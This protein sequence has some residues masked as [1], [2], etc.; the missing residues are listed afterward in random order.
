MADKQ[1]LLFPAFVLQVKEWHQKL[2]CKCMCG[3]S[4]AST[5]KSHWIPGSL[6][7]PQRLFIGSINDGA[8]VSDT[9][10]QLDKN[11]KALL[12]K[13]IEP[14]ACFYHLLL[15]IY[16]AIYL[17]GHFVQQANRYDMLPCAVL[18]C[19][20]KAVRWLLSKCSFLSSIGSDQ[21]RFR[22]LYFCIQLQLC[23]N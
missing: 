13:T 12:L 14:V 6:D 15:Y 11:Q 8:L 2:A 22:C 10:S 9:S 17:S 20:H 16:T 3:I 23:K 19:N 7:L 21:T 18:R 4:P 5:C 1:V